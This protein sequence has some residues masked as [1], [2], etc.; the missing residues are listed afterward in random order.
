[1]SSALLA[2]GPFNWDR[3]MDALRRLRRVRNLAGGAVAASVAVVMAVGA[4]TPGHASSITVDGGVSDWGV[5]LHNGGNTTYGGSNY[6]GVIGAYSGPGGGAGLIG[7]MS[8]VTPGNPLG[9][10]AEDTNDRAA[11]G[12]IVTPWEGGQKYDAEFMAVAL[13]TPLNGD[14]KHSNLSILIVSGLRPDNGATYFGPGDIRVNGLAGSFGIET[15]GGVGH[16]GGVDV[17]HQ[18]QASDGY[19]YTLTYGGGC[20]GCTSGTTADSAVKAGSIRQNPGWINDPLASAANGGASGGA[21]DDP[22]GHPDD[23]NLY[24][25]EDDD[26][27]QIDH[28]HAGTDVTP[29]DMQFYYTADELMDGANNKSVHSVIELS[30]AAEPFVVT[31]A[32]GNQTLSFSIDWGPGCNNDVLEVDAY[33]Y[34]PHQWVSEPPFAIGFAGSLLAVGFPLQRRRRAAKTK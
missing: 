31:D 28:A 9:P 23:L 15:G 21:Y 32:S 14:L 5:V 7:Y 25:F 17:A 8:P 33:A 22:N 11:N 19:T 27:S 10:N 16:T 26:R 20:I 3:L 13:S 34:Q 1:M 6:T 24:P 30:F 18:T 29:A 12:G 2:F 4:S